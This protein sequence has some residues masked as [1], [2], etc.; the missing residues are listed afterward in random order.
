MVKITMLGVQSTMTRHAKRQENLTQKEKNSQSI[1]IN[2]EMTQ[3][4]EL[5]EKD[6]KPIIITVF[7]NLK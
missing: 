3:M 6:I 4:L 2:S 7:H 1:K 5:A